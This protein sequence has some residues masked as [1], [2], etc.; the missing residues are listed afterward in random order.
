MPPAS[1]SGYFS[2]DNGNT[3]IHG[4]SGCIGDCGDWNGE[5][6]DSFNASSGQVYNPFSVGDQQLIDVLGYKLSS[7]IQQP[8]SITFSASPT[9]ITA[10]Q[11]ATLSWSSTNATSCTGTGFSASN[12]SGSVVVS[13]TVSTSYILSCTGAGGSTSKT[14]TLAVNVVSVG[15]IG[16][17]S[18]ETPAVGSYVYNPTGA[19]WAFIGGAGIE[20]N[21][22]AWNAAGAP[23]GIQAAFIQASGNAG[24][25]SQAV[26]ITNSGSYALAFQSAMRPGYPQYPFTVTV[27]GSTVGSFTPSSTSFTQFM[28]S[29][30]T[31][32]SGVHT[33]A[34][35]GS[36]SSVDESDFIDMVILTNGTGT[37]PPASTTASLLANPTSITAGQSSTLSWS[38]TNA[39]S[40]TGSNFTASGISGSTAVTPAQTTTYGVT[41]T[42][43][44]GSATQS[45]TVNVSTPTPAQPTASLSANPTSVTAGQSSTLSWSSTNAT[46]CS[47]NNFSASGVSGSVAVAPT[48]TT[49]YIINCTGAGGSVSSSATVTVSNPQPAFGIGASVQTNSNL[50][51]RNKAN[52][53]SGKIQC[54]Q[55]TGSVGTI[56]GG[57]SGAQGYTWWNVNFQTGCD[58]WVVQD[59]LNLL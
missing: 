29:S 43:T 27:D 52:T 22:S 39:T 47:G 23:D 12:T 7:N 15:N 21:G 5:A 54:T 49:T 17:A 40:C 42:G 44:G 36:A 53:N 50:N 1:G 32:S 25:I 6:N 46:N 34:F 58:G 19:T 11:S 16:N 33:I 30:F 14:I 31:L 13:P 2:F 35:V 4:Y 48:Q 57:P 3:Y 59:Y 45:A 56:I 18:F 51:V 10:G 20:A 24:T 55:P 8:P 9:S 41:C 38:S 37:P 28:T 26:S